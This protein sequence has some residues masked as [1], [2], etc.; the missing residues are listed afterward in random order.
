MQTS[1]NKH[2]ATSAKQ[3]STN[4]TI[5]INAIHSSKSNHLPRHG[6]KSNNL[7][8]HGCKSNHLQGQNK[9]LPATMQKTSAL[10]HKVTT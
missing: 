4:R 7:P 2:K 3:V 1:I 10:A 8:R 6:C 9:Y 5:S